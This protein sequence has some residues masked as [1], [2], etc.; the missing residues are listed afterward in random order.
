MSELIRHPEIWQRDA[1]ALGEAKA[2]VA[3]IK[4]ELDANVRA[5]AAGGW[6][7]SGCSSTRRTCRRSSFEAEA[8]QRALAPAVAAPPTL[9]RL[10][11]DDAREFWEK[12]FSPEQR[13]AVLRYLGLT[14]VIN[15]RTAKH[16]KNAPEDIEFRI[17]GQRVEMV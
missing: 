6:R 7:W 10:A 1:H 9:G 5:L 8:E 3:R 13:R 4:A 14:V 16:R 15:K 12:E 11:G 2:K 17:N